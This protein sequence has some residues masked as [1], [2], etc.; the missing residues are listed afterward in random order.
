MGT[1]ITVVWL[2]RDLRLHDH[3]ALNAA[4]A[5]GYPV[6]LLYVVEPDYWSLPDTALA[7]YPGISA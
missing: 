1:P 5:A 2:K 3:A 4:I 7:I 6:V